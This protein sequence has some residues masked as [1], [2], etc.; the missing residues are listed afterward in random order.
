MHTTKSASSAFAK[1]WPMLFAFLLFAIG[2][3]QA[4][5]KPD[6]DWL[7]GTWHIPQMNV[8]ETW[9]LAENGAGYEGRSVYRLAEGERLFEDFRVHLKGDSGF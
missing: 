7:L 5:E 6:L 4:Q 3:L 2:G 1:P 8:Y 9:E